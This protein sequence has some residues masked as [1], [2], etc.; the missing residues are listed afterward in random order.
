MPVSCG[1][2]FISGIVAEKREIVL[3]N[4]IKN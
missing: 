4:M 2:F 1:L 3:R